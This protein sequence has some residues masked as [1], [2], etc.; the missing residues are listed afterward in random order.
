MKKWKVY[1]GKKLFV[2][3]AKTGFDAI[4][5]ALSQREEHLRKILDA[6]WKNLK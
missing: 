1:F 2:V 3:Y 5:R 4:N 6:Y